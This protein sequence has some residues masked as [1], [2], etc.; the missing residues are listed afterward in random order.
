LEERLDAAG[1]CRCHK[2]YLVNLAAVAEMIPWF[3][4]GYQLKMDDAKESIVPVS[5]RHVQQ[6]K[7]RLG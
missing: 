5:R 4:G 7:G 6:V 2:G 3:S 1:F